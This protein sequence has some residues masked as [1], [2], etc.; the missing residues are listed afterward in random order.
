M[1]ETECNHLKGKWFRTS[2]G[3]VTMVCDNGPNCYRMRI[4][5]INSPAAYQVFEVE[6]EVSIGGKIIE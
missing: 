3:G 1:S 4:T 5:D 2:D 6:A